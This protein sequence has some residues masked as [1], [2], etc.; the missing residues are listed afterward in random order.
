MIIT[1]KKTNVTG[2]VILFS[3]LHPHPHPSIHRHPCSIKEE[4]LDESAENLYRFLYRLLI[5]HSVYWNQWT[6]LKSAFILES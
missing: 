3:P 2:R 5:V 4:I 6:I 1:K